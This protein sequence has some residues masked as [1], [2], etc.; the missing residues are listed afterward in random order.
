ML[1]R[2]L[3]HLRDGVKGCQE[4]AT[5]QSGKEH[6]ESSYWLPEVRADR[7][8]LVVVTD[9]KV[10]TNLIPFPFYYLLLA[11]ISTTYF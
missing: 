2:W 5:H 6:I 11:A 1:A 9:L 4:L 10:P 3:R 8:R 7:L